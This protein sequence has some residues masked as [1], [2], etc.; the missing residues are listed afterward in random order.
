MIVDDEANTRTALRDLLT[1][2]GYRNL[3]EA[4]NGEEA[5]KIALA[6]KAKL[7]AIIAD[8]E[9]PYMDGITLLKEV[10]Q[11]HD[12]DLALFILITSDLPKSQ[13]AELQKTNDRLD[14]SLIKP[15]RMGALEKA[16]ELAQTHRTQTRSLIA[17][18][19][20]DQKLLPLN[21]AAAEMNASVVR[22][23]NVN[24]LQAL[25][26]A[27]GSKLG[28][29][30]IDPKIAAL[31]SIAQW[32]ASFGKT[33]QGSATPVICAGRKPEVITPVRTLCRIFLSDTASV[34]E[35]KSALSAVRRHQETWLNSEL[36]SLDF[37]AALQA[38]DYSK[39]LV[40]AQKL[41]ALDPT[42]TEVRASLGEIHEHLGETAQ[43]IPHFLQALEFHPCQPRAY[44]K[45]LGA[46]MGSPTEAAS[47]RLKET[48][49][50]AVAY[51]PQHPG[52][53]WAAAL[54]YQ[55]AGEGNRAQE[56]ARRVLA[57]DSHHAQAR[58]LAP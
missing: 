44:I 7:R 22:V 56:V 34:T 13:L 11:R 25:I 52:A 57:I 58:Q 14:H 40:L 27:Q 36:V 49:D 6:E 30:A 48:A 17:A 41:L 19:C 45:L 20:E 35:W 12:L 42:N 46:L 28:L 31:D 54:A 37:K 5:L 18:V 8:W 53:L 50:Q 3:L 51:C 23:K 55:A 10:N 38:K 47:V 4:K 15:F 1:Q 26:L 9:M 43:A 32:L 39:A 29:L 24:E 33:H 16:L 2:L 21:Q